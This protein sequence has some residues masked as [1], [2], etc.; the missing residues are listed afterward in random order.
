MDNGNLYTM[1]INQRV[2]KVATK[3]KAPF[4]RSL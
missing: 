3:K 1:E 2:K 4:S